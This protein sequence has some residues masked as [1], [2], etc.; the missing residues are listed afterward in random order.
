VGDAGAREVFRGRLIRLE[1]RSDPYREIVRHPGSCAVVAITPSGEVLLVRQI[2][3]AA[4]RTLLEIP[5]GIMDVEGEDAAGCAARE[6]VE[7][8]GH[9]AVRLE[10]LG[11]F[12]ASAGFTDEAFALFLARATPEPET[13]PEEGIETVRMPLSRAVA[14]VRDWR[15]ADAKTALALLLAEHAVGVRWPATEEGGAG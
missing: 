14:E 11:R 15:I 6:L 9:R 5:A 2:R 8:T 10:P 1:V 13:A 7:E 12:L 4:G 3:E